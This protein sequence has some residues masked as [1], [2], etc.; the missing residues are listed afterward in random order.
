MKILFT[1]ICPSSNCQTVSSSLNFLV[2]NII[3]IN[4]IKIRGGGEE[5]KRR[6][7]KESENR[8]DNKKSKKKV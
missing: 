2:V 1:S 4:Y 7:K 5:K 3:I 8:E 6:K